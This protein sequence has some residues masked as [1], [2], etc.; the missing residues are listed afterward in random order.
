[1][2]LR[3]ISVD[4]VKTPVN[5]PNNVVCVKPGTSLGLRKSFFRAIFKNIVLGFL[6]FPICFGFFIFRYNRTGYDML[7]GSIVVE[8]IPNIVL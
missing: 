1:M 6:M 5:Y 3:V 2:G 4:E 8:Y 7:V